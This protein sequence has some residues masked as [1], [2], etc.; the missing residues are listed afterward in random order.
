MLYLDEALLYR[1]SVR[2]FSSKKVADADVIAVIEAG[3]SAPSAKNSQPWNFRVM[4]GAEKSG[5]ATA[6]K[7]WAQS[8]RS[9]KGTVEYSAEILLSAPV[10][11]AVCTKSGKRWPASDYISVGACI[12]NMSLKAVD[13]GLGSLIVCDVW[14]VE[15]EAR[16]LLGVKDEVTALF[17]LG[18]GTEKY[19]PRIRK[20]LK[21]KVVGIEVK[22]KKSGK[23]DDL[24]EACIG[25]KKFVFISYSHSDCATVIADICELK[26]HGVVLWYDRS[27]VYGEKWDRKAL[28]QI[29]SDNCVGVIVYVSNAS[30]R[31]DAVAQE[32]KKARECSKPVYSVHIGDKTLGGYYGGDGA[33]CAAYGYLDEKSKFI[34]RSSVPGDLNGIES[35]VKICDES[36]ATAASGIYDEF[37]YDEVNDGIRIKK[38]IGVSEDVVVP[39]RISGLPVVE[40]GANA[41]CENDKVRRVSLPYTVKRIGAGALSKNVNLTDVIIPEGV[42][43]IEDAAFRGCTAIKKILL[44]PGLKYL[45]EALF[46]DCVSLEECIVPYGVTEMGEAVFNGCTSLV[47]VVIPDTVKKMTEGGFFNCTNLRDLTIPAEIEGLEVQ[48]FETCPY[49]NVTAGGFVYRGG[50]GKKVE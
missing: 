2:E 41:I 5:I 12:E 22:V 24:P 13:C 44:P 38:Y 25:G 33:G 37:T 26:R 42:E 8:N 3:C 39:G 14:C 28:S 45:S 4:S 19:S 30:V 9:E 17:L 10:A 50:K 23:T 40:I 16:S 18:Y 48:S 32:L 47:R 31:S 29:A 36:G 43:R 34:S 11:I 21:S 46:R 1:R 49:V 35:I 15:K 27:I 7:K 6:M 20:P